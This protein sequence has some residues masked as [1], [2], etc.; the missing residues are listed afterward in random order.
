[1]MRTATLLC[2]LLLVA[3]S[4][5]GAATDVIQ[6]SD[7]D[8]EV[9]PTEDAAADTEAPRFYEVE[10]LVLLD[11]EPVEGAVVSQGGRE[12]RWVT[13]P[14]GKVVVEIDTT[15]IGD[16]AIVASHPEARIE[17]AMLWPG[18]MSVTIELDRFDPSDNPDYLFQDPGM[19]GHSPTSAYCGHCHVTIAK[20]FYASRHPF[21]A[22]NPA[23][24]DLY[25]GTSAA[26]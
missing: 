23:L 22:S 12:E 16:L 21:A 17:A 18:L 5:G 2:T 4:T 3:C 24:Q 7:G 26:R 8:T 25:S 1:M 15:V 14:D 6:P 19:P 20:D 10:T 11:G 9:N 13:G